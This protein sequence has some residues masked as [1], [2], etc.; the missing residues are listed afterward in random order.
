MYTKALNIESA[1]DLSK[2]AAHL[3]VRLQQIK[4]GTVEVNQNHVS[5]FRSLAV[6]LVLGAI[7]GTFLSRLVLGT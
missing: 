7:D 4:A 2:L 6:S 5:L 1:V 3:A